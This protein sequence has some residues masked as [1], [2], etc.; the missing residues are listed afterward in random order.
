MANNNQ[1]HFDF[2]LR[3]FAKILK[4]DNRQNFDGRVV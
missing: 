2:E 4:S 3:K 1:V